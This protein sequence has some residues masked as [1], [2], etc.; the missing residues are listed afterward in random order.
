MK[1]SVLVS[2]LHAHNFSQFATILPNGRN[3]RLQATLDV[4]QQ[5]TEFCDN[6]KVS[7]LFFLGDMF[8]SRTRLDVDVLSTT[9]R[10]W[11]D[12][13]AYVDEMIIL[14]GNH[15]Q[16]N[17]DGTVHS[18]EPFKAFARVIDKPWVGKIGRQRIAA[19]PFTTDIEEW[20]KWANS[21]PPNTDYFFF[22]QGVSQAKVGAFD[23]SVKA[24]IDIEDLPDRARWLWGG[25]YHKHQILPN[26]AGFVG[27]PLQH[28]FGERGE[29][30][31]FI[32][33]RYPDLAY[34]IESNAPKFFYYES[35]K[36]FENA[37]EKW[38]HDD[39]GTIWSGAD[40][41]RVK[42]AAEQAEELL[43]KYPR[44]Q[45]EVTMKLQL[46]EN[47]VDSEVAND[48]SMLL[49]AYIDKQGPELDKKL[50]L[51]FGLDFLGEE[52]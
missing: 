26:G 25:H 46:D 23:I 6:N 30:K 5:I 38:D 24:E 2:D 49:Q 33:H 36:K 14:T 37:V 3:S 21:I 8:H 41:I 15:D 7:N 9:W 35:L 40:Y 10:A 43:K 42:C 44:I 48:D 31:G 4:I 12:L 52:L 29:K 19:H 1:T 20:K 16:A 51:E 50:L 47:R 39:E 17:K 18:L 32:Y 27:S 13:R 11:A 45:T 28:N 22:H 34:Q